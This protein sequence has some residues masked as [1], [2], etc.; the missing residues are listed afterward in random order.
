MAYHISISLV[1]IRG[2]WFSEYYVSPM[3]QLIAKLPSYGIDAAG[4]TVQDLPPILP[5]V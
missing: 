3:N 1:C 2:L 4:H 5:K